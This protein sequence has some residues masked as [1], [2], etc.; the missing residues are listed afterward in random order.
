MVIREISGRCYFDEF[1]GCFCARP[2]KDGWRNSISGMPR[3][4][5]IQVGKSANN[6]NKCLTRGG[7]GALE[8][9]LGQAG[10]AV[11]GSIL[12]SGVQRF[13]ASPDH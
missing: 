13:W 1:F 3:T 11:T 6:L 7:L 5:C 9:S 12:V 2:V 8:W 10:E 4:A